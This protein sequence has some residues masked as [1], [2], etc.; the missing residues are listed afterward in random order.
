MVRASPLSSSMGTE[1]RPLDEPRIICAGTDSS[2]LE[3]S[4]LGSKIASTRRLR[5]RGVAVL[6]CEV[7]VLES[8]SG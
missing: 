4:I 3:Q 1:P 6:R 8:P 2:S 5:S 7:V